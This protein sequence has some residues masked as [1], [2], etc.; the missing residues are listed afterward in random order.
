MT[1]R[2]PSRHIGVS[3]T[4]AENSHLQ[5]GPRLGNQCA[6]PRQRFFLKNKKV[7]MQRELKP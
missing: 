1:S 6:F 4:P 5:D 7:K 2:S 3:V